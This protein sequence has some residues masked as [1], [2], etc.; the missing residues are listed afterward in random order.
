MADM[1]M[2]GAITLQAEGVDAQEKNH[3]TWAAS[4][5]CPPAGLVLSPSLSNFYRKLQEALCS[6][7]P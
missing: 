4:R 5:N 7:S 6:K 3:R 1:E 2:I